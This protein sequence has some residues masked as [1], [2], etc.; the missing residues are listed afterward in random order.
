MKSVIFLLQ[1]HVTS[2][3]LE[4][5][6]QICKD[7][8]RKTERVLRHARDMTDSTTVL[9]PSDSYD[10]STFKYTVV[11]DFVRWLISWKPEPSRRVQIQF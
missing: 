6:I 11:P 3:Q 7:L 2:S 8:S 4:G 5:H 9:L 10:V 1:D